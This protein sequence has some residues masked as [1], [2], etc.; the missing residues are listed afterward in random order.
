MYTFKSYNA[1][2]NEY[3]FRV[4]MLILRFISTK[5][6]SLHENILVNEFNDKRQYNTTFDYNHRI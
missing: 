6:T 2:D 4:F 3:I 1:L 5:I